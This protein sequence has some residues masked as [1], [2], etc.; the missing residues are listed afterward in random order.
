MATLTG[1]SCAISDEQVS[2]IRTNI[3]VLRAID[4]YIDFVIA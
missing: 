2:E 4:L 1:A 3:A